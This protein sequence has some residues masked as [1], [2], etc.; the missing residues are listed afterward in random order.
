MKITWLDA[1]RV[2]EVNRVALYE[3]EPHGR[4]PGADLEAIVYRPQ[5]WAHYKGVRSLYELA[6][7]YAAAIAEG[8]PFQDG[9]KRTAVLSAVVFL[10]LNG[11]DL[12]LSNEDEIYDLITDIAATD[13]RVSESR[14]SNLFKELATWIQRNTTGSEE[15]R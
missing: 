4:N 15:A 12:D 1:G 8:H 10:D 13:K 11:L 6:A 9:N 2:E 14:D 3:G 5:S 7:L